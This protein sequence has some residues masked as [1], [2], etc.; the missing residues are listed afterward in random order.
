MRKIYIFDTTLRDGEQSPGV[1]L[2]TPEKVE[3]A[4]QLERLGVD[5]IEAGFPAASPGDLAAVNAVANAVKNASVIGLSRSREQDIDAVRE[6]LKGAQDPCLHLFLATSP[7]HRQ[8]KLRMDKDQVRDTARSAIRYARKYFDKVEFSLEDAGRTELEFIAE[9]TKMAIEEGA[10]VVNLPDTVG[11]L[12]PY[13][14]GNIFKYVKENVPGVEKVQLSAHCHDDL[15]MATANALAAILNGADQVEGTINGIGERA[16]NTALEEVA[17]ALETRQDFY[18]AKTS[19][20]LSEIAR[21]SRLVSKLTGM[22]V[23]GN[24]AIVG[25][26]A[27]AHESG[28]HQDGMLKEKSTYEIMTPETI[29]LKESKLVMGK[30]SGRHAFREHLIELGFELDEEAVNRAFAKFKV[31]AD[32]KK[33]VTDDDLFALLEERLADTPEFFQLDS[34]FVSFDSE[35]EP[36]ARVRLSTIDGGVREEES[37]GNGAVDSIYNAIDKASQED[38]TLSDYSIKAVTQGK[39]ALGEVHVALTQ[40]GITAQ[41]RGVSTDILEASARAYV[42]S[43]NRLVEKRKTGRRDN[44]SMI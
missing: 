7:I 43:L 29:G 27:F 1:N 38:V 3:I 41:G 25:A 37:S 30:H 17:M 23:P 21:T 22:V 35:S 36:T 42:D 28:I 39:D 33:E 20:T 18:G 34:L 4:H 13:E 11:Y 19:F 26:N 12:T 31:L 8:Y 5:R 15:G 14:Y 40:E 44:I 10:Y 32:K 16:G 24:K 2:N 9:M 6:A